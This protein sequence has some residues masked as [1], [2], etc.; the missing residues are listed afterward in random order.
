[1]DKRI[2]KGFDMLFARFGKQNWWPGDSPWEICA[3]A[4]LTQNTSWNNV[5]KAI[6]LMKSAGALSPDVVVELP[7]SELE[8]LIRP[9]GF[10]R[11]KA[12]RLKNMAA[13]WLDNARN[14]KLKPGFSTA[15]WRRRLLEVNGIGPETADSILLYCF[16]QPVFVIDAYTMR[17]SARHF[18]ADPEIS[19]HELQKIFMEN[20]SGSA[21]LFNEYHALLVRNAKECCRKNVCL[22]DC[23]LRDI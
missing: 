16:N 15:E 17:I 4:V 20:L 9:S 21:E 13:W 18:G 1:M 19:Y 12:Q 5:E 6:A 14:S 8:E 11:I 10:F 23:P 7:V 2:V 3:G 22:E